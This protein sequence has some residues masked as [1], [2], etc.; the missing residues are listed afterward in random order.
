MCTAGP[1]ENLWLTKATGMDT[2]GCDVPNGS[3][4][5]LF[6]AIGGV[7]GPHGGNMKN[8]RCCNYGNF[9]DKNHRFH[10]PAGHRGVR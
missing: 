3:H 4:F 6:W 9:G 10:L 5:D 7:E 1:N 8:W 2:N